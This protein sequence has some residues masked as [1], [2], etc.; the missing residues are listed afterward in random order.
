MS[1]QSSNNKRIA[2]NTI[3][4]YVRM[5]FSIVV[6]LYTSRVV[7][8]TLGVEDYGIYGVVGGVVAMFSFLNAA[9]SGATSRFLTFEMGKGDNTRLRDTFS[10]AMIVHVG[11]ALIIS[12]LALTVGL[13][14]LSNKLVIPDG[15]MTAAYW[16]YICSILSMFVGV[17]Q[18]P[19][20]AAIIAHEKMDVY[21]YVELLHVFLKLGIVYLLLLG[22]FDKLILYSILILGVG[23]IIAVTYR[24]YA[25]RHFEECH[26]RWIIRKELLRPL[27]SF[28]GWNVL[29]ECG[30]NFRV[31]GS[32]IVLNMIFGPIVNAAGGIATTV[33]GILLGFVGNI[34]T[35]V[36]PQ[37]I[38][39][40]GENN[41]QRM[42]NLMLSSVRLNL[43][44]ASFITL[45]VIV[46]APYIL[47]LWL[48]DVPQ[49]SIEFCQLLLFS[50]YIT[51]V[52]QIVIIGIHASGNIKLTSISR[53]VVYISTPVI[54]YA[55]VYIFSNPVL[56]YL[57]IVVSQMLV[58]LIDIYILH[59]NIPRINA[60]EIF[61]DYLKAIAILGAILGVMYFIN[62]NSSQSFLNLCTNVFIEFVLIV[63]S[64]WLFMFK[65]I[66]KNMI[67]SY[68]NKI[69]KRL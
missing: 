23:V 8:Q 62:Q 22:N 3:M 29:S 4:L 15:R 50:I 1:D 39:S 14:F 37:I 64:F 54:I 19:Y 21:A 2:K 5:L 16:V 51:S 43:L 56:G 58:C 38:K 32:N 35:A 13:W 6:S 44:L 49:Y 9:M 18:V 10:S 31:Y 7:L 40:Y 65:S 20:N 63:I 55:A 57:I 67:L 34:V 17:T 30:Y 60:L 61:T 68:M 28:S 46:D 69:Q 52:S 48:K 12:I 33:Q 24:I 41:L 59:R 27:L 53:N 25:I 66:E 36:R 47:Q 45:P 42:N 11:I 26:F